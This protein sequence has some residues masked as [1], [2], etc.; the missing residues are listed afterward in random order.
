MGWLANLLGGGGE[1]EAPAPEGDPV[2]V[3]QVLAVIESIRPLLEADGGDIRLLAVEDGWVRVRLAGACKGCY[4]SPMTLQG[5]L[6]PKLRE[7]IKGFRG[8]RTE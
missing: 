8:L 7:E 3:A 4:A 6:E 1:E 2:Q 5:V